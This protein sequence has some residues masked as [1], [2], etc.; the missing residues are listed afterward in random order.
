MAEFSR[1]RIRDHGGR[2]SRAHAAGP[3]GC[4]RSWS[5]MISNN[6][7]AATVQGTLD[8]TSPNTPELSLWVRAEDPEGLVS[9]ISLPTFFFI[10][11]EGQG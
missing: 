6:N 5:G 1:P 8:S 7:G 4:A 3:L 10:G 9:G 2:W 11:E